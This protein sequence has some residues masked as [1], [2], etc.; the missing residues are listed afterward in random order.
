MVLWN[1]TGHAGQTKAQN[2]MTENEIAK[3]IVDAACINCLSIA[4]CL[5]DAIEIEGE[6]GY[7]YKKQV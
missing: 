3:I 4:V 6:L 7:Y 1:L 5:N 2:I